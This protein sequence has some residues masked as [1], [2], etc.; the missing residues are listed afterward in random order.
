MTGTYTSLEKKNQYMSFGSQ[1]CKAVFPLSELGTTQDFGGE[2][3]V[4]ALDQH[5]CLKVSVTVSVTVG[6]HFK[7][8]LFKIYNI[9]FT[10]ILYVN[11]D[12]NVILWITL[13]MSSGE[14]FSSKYSTRSSSFSW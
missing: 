2:K 10:S 4:A 11:Y 5:Q 1:A 8:L 6:E 7:D 12:E 9:K 13:T 14:Q 3:A